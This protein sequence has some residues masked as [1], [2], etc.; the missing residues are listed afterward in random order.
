MELLEIGDIIKSTLESKVSTY[1]LTFRITYLKL[2]IFFWWHW[3]W[4]PGPCTRQACSP[5]LSYL[6]TLIPET[7]NTAALAWF[8]LTFLLPD[9]LTSLSTWPETPNISYCLRNK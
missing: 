8:S 4:N 5:P 3:G 6:H 9:F 2:F 1:Y 7:F